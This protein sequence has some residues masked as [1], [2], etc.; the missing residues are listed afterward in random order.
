VDS[1]TNSA[2]SLNTDGDILAP[3][4]ADCT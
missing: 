1:A 2:G 4:S 3:N